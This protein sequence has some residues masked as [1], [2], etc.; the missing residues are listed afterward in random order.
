MSR[1]AS[2]EPAD[3]GMVRRLGLAIPEGERF[4]ETGSDILD[5][6]CAGWSITDTVQVRS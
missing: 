4:G 6:L 3:I 5:R 2:H 1:D